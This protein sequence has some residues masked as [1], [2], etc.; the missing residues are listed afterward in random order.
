MFLEATNNILYEP[1]SM[2]IT[3]LLDYDFSCISHPSYEFLRSFD[4]Y[5]GQFRGWSGDGD[6]E[7]LALH[8][9]KLHGFPS[10]LPVSTKDGVNWEAVKVWED[11][12]EKAQVQRPRTMKGIDKV[13]DIDAILRG[14]TPWRVTNSDMMRI[15]SEEIIMRCRNEGEQHLIKMLQR[16]GF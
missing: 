5:A 10:P 9:A 7:Q 11:Q 14:I 1:T 4:G 13:A 15:Q 16:L 12:L 3:A 2:R 6:S 8:E